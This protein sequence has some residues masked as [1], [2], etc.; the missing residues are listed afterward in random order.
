MAFCSKCGN[1]L[2]DAAAF[3][4]RCGAPRGVAPAPNAAPV[5]PAAPM[6]NNSSF[7]AGMHCPV[8]KSTNLSP[9]VGSFEGVLAAD[10][11]CLVCASCGKQFRNIH[12]VQD[13]LT[14]NQKA[15]TFSVWMLV[16]GAVAALLLY[17]L[18]RSAGEFM[19]VVLLPFI[20]GALFFAVI[21]VVQTVK[22]SN[23]VSRLKEELAYLQ[24]N[25][26]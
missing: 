26:F 4:D 17:M 11:G 6:P 20:I 22:Y 13:E 7:T 8:C 19:E 23:A 12:R 18:A 2:N 3:C 9:L 14:S 15:T 16:L 21:Y 10:N 25:C 5:P 24:Q 1:Q